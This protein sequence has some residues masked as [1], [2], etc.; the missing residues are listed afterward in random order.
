MRQTEQDTFRGGV[1]LFLGFF[2]LLTAL[3]PFG[4][5]V[6]TWPIGLLAIWFSVPALRLWWSNQT[7]P[8]IT[9]LTGFGLGVAAVLLDAVLWM[10]VAMQ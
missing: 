5:F 3:I 8:H 9:L 7:R 2:A 4:G 6:Y 1:V 10:M